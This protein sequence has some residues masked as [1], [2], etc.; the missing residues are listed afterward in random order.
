MAVEE[1]CV[2]VAITAIMKREFTISVSNAQEE[3]L[4]VTTTTIIE[5]SMFPVAVELKDVEGDK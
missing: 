2:V 4:S 3:V 1:L 5:M